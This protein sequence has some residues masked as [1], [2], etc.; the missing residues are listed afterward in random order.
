[1]TNI[2]TCCL[3]VVF[4][5]RIT[6][7]SLDF[8]LLHQISRFLDFQ[9]SRFVIESSKHEPKTSRNLDIWKSRDLEIW[10]STQHRPEHL[11]IWKT[12]TLEI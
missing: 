6:I 8:G 10:K 1:M 3:D 5:L 7:C 9:T 12:E 11:E 2:S 4:N